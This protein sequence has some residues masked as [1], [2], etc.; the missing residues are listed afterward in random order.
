MLSLLLLSTKGYE[1]FLKKGDEFH[2]KFDNVNAVI[3][4][5][6]AYKIAPANYEVLFKLVWA[7]NDAG[8][9]F[10]ELRNMKESEKYI[11]HA[12]SYAEKFHKLYPDSAS[13]Y[14]YLA[15]SYGNL[16]TFK[17]GNEKIK[18]ARKVEENAK[19]SIEINKNQYTAYVI[20][21]IYNREVASLGF[22]E[23]IFANTFFGGMPEGSYEESVT[24]LNKALEIEPNTIVATYQLSKTYKN[25]GN[26]AKEKELLQKL[27]E[28]K[29]KNFRDKFALEKAKRRLENL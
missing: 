1:D 5:E 26:E 14:C 2:K 8:E 23:R 22:F 24:M 29:I 13:T 28:Y 18:L 17:G 11:N 20:L 9:E 7:Y 10:F 15:M 16:A 3:N 25:M 6:K 4:Y 21:G 19:K 12:I 27:L